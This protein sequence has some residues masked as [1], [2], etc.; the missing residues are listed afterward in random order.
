MYMNLLRNYS[1]HTEQFPNSRNLADSIIYPYTMSLTSY[2]FMFY[3]RADRMLINNSLVILL[4]LLL[5][6]LRPIFKHKHGF[7]F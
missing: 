1:L 5:K 3:G 7:T 2:I 6:R 4:L